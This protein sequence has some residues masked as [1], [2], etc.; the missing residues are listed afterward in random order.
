[1]KRSSMLVAVLL[2]SGCF[3]MVGCSEPKTAAEK[4][5]AAVSDGTYPLNADERLMAEANAKSFFNKEYPIYE[6]SPRGMFVECKP[7]DSNSNG[8]VTCSGKVPEAN[9]TY[10]DTTRY[11]GYRKD[12]VG[13]S[14]EDTGPK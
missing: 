13:C 12:L 9:G 6:G 11:C 7:S 2:A 8:T 4:V 1:M 10:K 14:P 5:T 3:S